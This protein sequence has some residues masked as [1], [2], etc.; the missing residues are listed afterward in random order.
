MFLLNIV[1]ITVMKPVI[2]NYKKVLM[3]LVMFKKAVIM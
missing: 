2:R 1:N 3:S